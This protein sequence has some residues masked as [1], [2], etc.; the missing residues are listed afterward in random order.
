[1][2]DLATLHRASSVKVTFTREGQE[3]VTGITDDQGAYEVDL[4]KGEGWTVS[5]RSPKHRRGQLVDL[6]PSYRVRDSDERK[7]ALE[8]INDGDLTPAPVEWKLKQSS[9][10]LDL[11]VVPEY[12]TGTPN[13]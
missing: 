8:Q 1:M 2:F 10:H 4:P 9:V 13:N 5:V 6:D 11:V 12:W 7:A 3:P